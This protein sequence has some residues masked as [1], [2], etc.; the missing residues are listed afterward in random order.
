[1]SF[2]PPPPPPPSTV[3][4]SGSSSSSTLLTAAQ[5]GHPPSTPEVEQLLQLLLASRQGREAEA[6]HGALLSAQLA[7]AG[8]R[9]GVLEEALRGAHLEASHYEG[10]REHALKVQEALE[11]TSGQLA[12]ALELLH[13]KTAEASHTQARLMVTQEQLAGAG[14]RC[15]ELEAQL[16]ATRAETGSHARRADDAEAQL[17]RMRQEQQHMQARQQARASSSG[18]GGSAEEARAALEHLRDKLAAAAARRAALERLVRQ[19]ASA[20]ARYQQQQPQLQQA[21]TPPPP[22]TAQQQQQAALEDLTEKAH[23]IPET[24]TAEEGLPSPRS[25]GGEIEPPRD[26]PFAAGDGG[27][28]A[29]SRKAAWISSGGGG[30]SS[31][32]ST[33]GAASGSSMSTSG[34]ASGSSMSTSGAG[35]SQTTEARLPPLP[36]SSKQLDIPES[37]SPSLSPSEPLLQLGQ[38]QRQQQPQ[39]ARAQS[40]VALRSQGSSLRSLSIDEDKSG[41]PAAQNA[42]LR[43]KP[44]EQP[45]P[46]LYVGFLGWWV[47]EV[48]LREYFEDYGVVRSVKVT[49]LAGSAMPSTK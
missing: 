18:V 12:G 34:A 38:H 37:P 35:S 2:P 22:Q 11:S 20:L 6:R 27:G 39:Y 30:R 17:K 31:S 49:A 10:M 44:S 5:Q 9:I 23:S 25:G 45:S 47:S 42:R 3:S 7:A 41:D 29:A 14:A 32:M 13:A 1:M 24:T 48:L 26:S 15:A 36:P 8:A 46:C 4:L 21:P 43:A 16:G 33:S 19:Q 28:D 40:S